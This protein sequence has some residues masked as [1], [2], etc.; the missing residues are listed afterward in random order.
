M[1]AELCAAYGQRALVGKTCSDQLVPDGYVE[2]TQ[3]SLADTEAFIVRVRQRFGGER[4]ALVLPV[5]TP[6]FVRSSLSN[7]SS[8]PPAYYPEM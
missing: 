3:G 2:T 4:E 8:P 7:A 5:I 1:L 6:R